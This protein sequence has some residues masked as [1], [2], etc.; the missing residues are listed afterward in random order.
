MFGT[1]ENRAM[2]HFAVLL[3]L[4]GLS[5]LAPTRSDAADAYVIGAVSLRAGPDIG[6]PSIMTLPAGMPVSVYGCTDGWEWCDVQAEDNR[7]WVSGQF[8]QYDYQ[9][10][11]VL[12]PDYGA[13]VGIPIVAFVLGAYWDQ[14]YRSRSWYRDRDSW[15]HRTFAH[16]PPPR[17][18]MQPSRPDYRS[19]SVAPRPPVNRTQSAAP[20]P[21]VNRT[22]SA[23]PRPPVN[24]TRPSGA[25]TAEQSSAITRQGRTSQARP[26]TQVSRPPS[27]QRSAPAS[28]PSTSNAGH[29]A[30]P[31]KGAAQRPAQRAKPVPKKDNNSKDGNATDGGHR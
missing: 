20:R 14:H 11:R 3:F 13:R 27:S 29:P 15:S 6:Y 5:A 18:T 30:P 24:R 26:K 31:A 2:K 19:Q 16:R 23:A 25:A 28:R 22:Q 8:L 1:K 17:P 21:P 9:N 10:Q 4:L 12:L 7:G